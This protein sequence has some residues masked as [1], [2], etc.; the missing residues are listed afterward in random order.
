MTG[1]EVVVVAEAEAV[2][3]SGA[4]VASEELV[5]DSEEAGEDLED[6]EREEASEEDLEE[7]AVVKAAPKCQLQE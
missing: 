7:G 6:E 5:E 1:L 3:A 4:G 2:E